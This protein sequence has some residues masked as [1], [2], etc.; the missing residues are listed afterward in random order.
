MLERHGA[1][2]GVGTA[3]C[4]VWHGTV[5]AVEGSRR[6]RGRDAGDFVGDCTREEFAEPPRL[7]APF[8]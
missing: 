6:M 5:Q 3:S 4:T 1:P 8:A 2:P 7:S